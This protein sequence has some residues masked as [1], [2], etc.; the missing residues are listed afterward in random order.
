MK[1]TIRDLLWLVLVAAVSFGWL[2]S[3]RRRV[4]QIDDAARLLDEWKTLTADLLVRSGA[5][6]VATESLSATDPI[7][8]P[9][10]RRILFKSERQ[11]QLFKELQAHGIQ[12]V[13]LPPQPP[14]QP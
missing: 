4:S 12:P 13:L 2:Q 10:A 9:G 7:F 1:L 14:A 3:D 8:T 6:V 11:E 5:A